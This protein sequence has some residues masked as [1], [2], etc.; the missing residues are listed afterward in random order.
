MK[1]LTVLL[2]FLFVLSSVEISSQIINEDYLYGTWS[3]EKESND[4][5]FF[6]K[7]KLSQEYE[8][9]DSLAKNK[10][11]KTLFFNYMQSNGWLLD[12]VI[13][14]IEEISSDSLDVLLSK[15]SSYTLF[16]QRFQEQELNDPTFISTI[17]DSPCLQFLENKE[18]KLSQNC[19]W[20]G[21]PPISYCTYKGTWK[22]NKKEVYE[23]N[24]DFWGG[25]IKK[26]WEI[27]SLSKEEMAIISF[28]SKVIYDKKKH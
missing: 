6:R 4:T 18:L 9:M 22:K 10:F 20:C 23:L 12:F 11:I 15:S 19:G 27:F 3:Y 24:Y 7:N 5:I 2:T 21:T 25:K 1:I 17:S 13:K 16:K 26:S 14:N 8:K 28:D